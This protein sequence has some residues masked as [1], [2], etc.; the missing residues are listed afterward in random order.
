M[1]FNVFCFVSAR[2]VLKALVYREGK[3]TSSMTSELAVLS[4]VNGSP[5]A[6]GAIMQPLQKLA[7]EDKVVQITISKKY[8]QCSFSN[9]HLM[10]VWLLLLITS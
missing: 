2:P 10:W 1:I 3:A 5:R 7:M 9:I 8:F 6:L 4:L